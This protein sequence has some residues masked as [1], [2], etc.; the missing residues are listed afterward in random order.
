MTLGIFR[1]PP[2][3]EPA[4][5]SSGT[6]MPYEQDEAVY[7]S[8]GPFP[9]ECAVLEGVHVLR[10]LR[11]ACVRFQPVRYDPATGE[12]ATPREVRPARPIGRPT[13]W[14]ALSR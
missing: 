8:P 5:R 4:D 13:R 6:T 7:G 2:L 3:Q 9:S 12:V 11:V 14:D 10:D 1:I